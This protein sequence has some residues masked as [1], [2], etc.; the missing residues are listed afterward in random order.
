M[1]LRWLLATLHLLA[2]GIGLGA[3][4]VRGRALLRV[5]EGAGF[6]SVFLADT[7]WGI[8]FLLWLSTGL[9]RAFAGFEK[10][11][12]Y[13]LHNPFFLTKMAL[14]VIIVVLEVRP[15]TALIRWRIQL[16]KGAEPDRSLAPTLARISFLQTVLVVLMLMAA[17]AMARGLG[18]A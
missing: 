15:M 14:F 17:T 9:V 5:T 1:F 3:I 16:A 10:G 13:Y 18:M 4:W 6:R 7:G 11:T 2:L 8:A 12:D